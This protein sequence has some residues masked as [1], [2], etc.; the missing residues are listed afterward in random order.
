MSIRQA[1]RR[2]AAVLA[3][4]SAAGAFSIAV[5]GDPAGASP[6]T[7]GTSVPSSAVPVG[8][9][10]AGAPF[11]SGQGINIVLPANSVF[12]SNTNLNIV[13]CSAPNGVI[14]T[15]TAAC[16][17][18]T[19]QGLTLKS[20]S[21]GSVN[22]QTEEHGQLYPVYAT[23]DSISLGEGSSSPACG[24]TAAT[25]CILY[26]G[27]NYND[28]TQPHLWSQPFYVLANSDDQGENPGDGTGTQPPAQTPEV[29]LAILLPGAALALFG[30]TFMIRRR[31]QHQLAHGLDHE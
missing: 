12:S 8:T 9:F 19:I 22:Y 10:T 6:P 13:E 31:R 17:G 16:D 5:L 21:D 20:N 14:P 2:A 23:P 15:N 29:P 28:F 3:A 7:S 30:G 26:I 1:A 27:Y 25:E 24:D 11:S 18:N 4:V